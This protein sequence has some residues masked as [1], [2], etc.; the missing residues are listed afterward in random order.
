M[1][2]FNIAGPVKENKHYLIPP[3]DRLNLDD[4]LEYIEDEKYFI[5]HA[6]GKVEKQQ[7][8]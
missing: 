3:L 2:K 1:K 6:P 7:V 8:Y 5:L 4:I